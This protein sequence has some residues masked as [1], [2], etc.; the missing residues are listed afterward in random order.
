MKFMKVLFFIALAAGP[1]TGQDQPSAQ[2][3]T[4]FASVV[5]DMI[6]GDYDIIAGPLQMTISGHVMIPEGETSG[7]GQIYPG[8]LREFMVRMAPPIPDFRIEETDALQPDWYWDAAPAGSNGPAFYLSSKDL[9][10]LAGCRIADMPR[11]IGTFQTQAQDGTP[12]FHT[13]RL[14]LAIPD[15]MIGSWRFTA[16]P[17]SGPVQG[18]RYVIFDRTNP[19]IGQ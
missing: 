18:L 12:L 14:V 15:L 8:P 19:S 13:M 6:H 1:A 10:I 7:V 3:N 16:Q 9:E 17:S 5:A 2:D 4:C 11:F